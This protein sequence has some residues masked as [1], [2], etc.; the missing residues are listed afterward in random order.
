MTTR[1]WKKITAAV[2]I[3]ALIFVTVMLGIGAIGGIFGGIVL[4]MDKNLLGFVIAE[5]GGA[6]CLATM[7][8]MFNDDII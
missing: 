7:L 1:L 5:V 2:Q 6:C 4:L 8:V 3:A